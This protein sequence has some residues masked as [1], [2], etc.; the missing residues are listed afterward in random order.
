MSPG[1]KPPLP[2]AHGEPIPRIQVD[3]REGGPFDQIRHIATIAV[4][5][6]SVGPDG[7][8][9]NPTQTRAE[10]TRLQMREA[11]L[12]L[13]ELGLIDIDAERLAAS[14]SWPARRAVQ[15]G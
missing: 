1:P 13:L 8:Y 4:D 10:T 14:R 3:E 5:L 7:P 11:L 2:T 9:Y 6:W 12:Y 15:E